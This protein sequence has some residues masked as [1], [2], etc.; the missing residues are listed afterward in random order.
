MT[1]AEQTRD[2]RE[3][4][5]LA[6]VAEHAVT[7]ASIRSRGDNQR[8][9]PQRHVEALTAAIGRP[10][11]I[12]I[13]LALIGVWV[14]WN[15][16][17]ELSGGSAIDPAP[18]FWLQGVVGLYAALISTFVLAT[19]NREKR[20][21]EQRAYLELQVNLLAEQKTAKIIEL[22]EELRRDMPSVRDRVD[23]QADAMQLPVDTNAVL[24]VL[25]GTMDVAADAD[26]DAAI[27]AGQ[28]AVVTGHG[29]RSNGA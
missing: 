20:H 21:A 10:S 7:I 18:F 27:P 26:A 17:E 12:A 9:S 16:Y 2:P 4:A 14:A 15:A 6:Q 3:A 19:Q 23:L 28:N 29:E 24:D 1:E 5:Q 8:S 25:E 11:T 13:L 22:L